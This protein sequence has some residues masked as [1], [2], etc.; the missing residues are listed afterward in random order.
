M[1][2]VIEPLA[3][4]GAKILGRSGG[5]KAPLAIQGGELKGFPTFLPL[6]VPR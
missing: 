6:P 5:S 4:M 3:K 1:G 2:R